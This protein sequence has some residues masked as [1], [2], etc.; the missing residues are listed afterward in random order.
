[1]TT[2]VTDAANVSI[3]HVPEA[4]G[5]ASSWLLSDPHY[6]S[7]QPRLQEAVVV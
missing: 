2:L 7:Q 1:M 6:R 5:A 4:V 3:I